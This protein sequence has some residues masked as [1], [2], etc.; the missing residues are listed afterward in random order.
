M[1]CEVVLFGESLQRFGREL[2]APSSSTLNTYTPQNAVTFVLKS[3]RTFN[4][5]NKDYCGGFFRLIY[6]ENKIGEDAACEQSIICMRRYT[7]FIMY[8]KLY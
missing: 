1:E 7:K 5:T 8:I 4:F 3:A 2:A 6:K